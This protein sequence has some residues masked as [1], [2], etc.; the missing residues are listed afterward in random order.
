MKLVLLQLAAAACLL[1]PV[2]AAQGSSSQNDAGLHGEP[3]TQALAFLR[4]PLDDHKGRPEIPRIGFGLFADCGRVADSFTSLRKS[5][6]D[7]QPI[8][9]LEISRNLYERDWL[10]SLHGKQRWVGFAR[11]NPQAGFARTYE[12]GPVLEGPLPEGPA[13]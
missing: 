4:I 11:W 12:F 2:A 7:G 10:I 3:D 9:S 8:R 5:A 13:N 1:A 6:C